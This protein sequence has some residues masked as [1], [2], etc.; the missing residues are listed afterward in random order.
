[1]HARAP[2]AFFLSLLFHTAIVV[3]ILVLAFVVQ[4]RM[5]PMQIFELVAGPPTDPTATAAPALGS[6]EGKV[7][8]K[9]LEPPARSEPVAEEPAPRQE[10][11]TVVTEKTPAKPQTKLSY[12]Q[13]V[14]KY[15]QPAPSKSAD[16]RAP[17]PV[18]VPKIHAK[19]IAEGV[20]GGSASSTGGGGGH[21]LTAG[22]RTALDAYIARLVTA[23]RQNLEKPPGLS[24]LLSADVEFLI[25]ADGTISR[26]HIVR[27]SGNAAFDESCIDAFRRM[28]SVGPKP[29]GKSVTW[30]MGFKMKDD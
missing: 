29:D 21:A 25:A 6:P 30:V 3:A 28:G 10:T 11:K 22:Q 20:L 9:I 13:Y 7:E 4:Q 15:G 23:L 18:A 8:V 5:P 12:D 26:I 17:R 24:D 16:A 1:M 14:K 2:S 19:G 27:S